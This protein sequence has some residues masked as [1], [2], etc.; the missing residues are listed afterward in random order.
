MK[1]ILTVVSGC[2]LVR[3]CCGDHDKG[4]FLHHVQSRL[5]GRVRYRGDNDDDD[6]KL[7]INQNK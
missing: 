2:G 6:D 4:N 3:E 1:L 5:L 7:K